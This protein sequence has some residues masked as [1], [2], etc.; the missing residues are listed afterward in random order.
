MDDEH[1]TFFRYSD[2]PGMVGRVGTRFGQRG[3]NI[4]GAAVGREPPGYDGRRDD[5]AVMAITTDSPVPPE[6]VDEIVATDGFLS[7]RSVSLA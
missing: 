5:V 2:V 6:V 1:F 7:G 3:I 4:S